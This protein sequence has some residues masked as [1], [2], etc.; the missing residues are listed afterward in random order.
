MSDDI[1][2]IINGVRTK[3]EGD[4][5]AQH[6]AEIEAN[7]ALQPEQQIS[8]LRVMRNQK[9][10]ASDWIVTKSMEAGEPVPTDWQTY[11]QE[12]RDITENYVTKE[13][14]V[15]PTKPGDS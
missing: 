15:W 12:L 3:L 2:M 8:E 13:E 5:L 4:E 6:Q 9:L 11:R 1:Y 10:D 7:I 14:V